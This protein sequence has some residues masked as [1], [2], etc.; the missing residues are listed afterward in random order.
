MEMKRFTETSAQGGTAIKPLDPDCG[1]CNFESDK[2]CFNHL[3]AML[4]RLKAYEDS[5][6]M[7][8]K[9]TEL[10]AENKRLHLIAE[11]APKPMCLG[12]ST[13]GGCWETCPAYR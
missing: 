13:C 12:E 7:P 1:A 4:Q 10:L 5:G 3:V 6:L 8:E 2:R 9:I 11:A